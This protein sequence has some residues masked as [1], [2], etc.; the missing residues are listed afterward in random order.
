MK[1]F[2]QSAIDFSADTPSY[3]EITK[4]IDNMSSSAS[5]CPFDQ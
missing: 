4:I 5:P 2:D 1:K 3:E